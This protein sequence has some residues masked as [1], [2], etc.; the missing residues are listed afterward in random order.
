VIGTVETRKHLYTPLRYPGGKTSLSSYFGKVLHSNG[1][2][3]PTY[4]EP[5]AGGA[6][7]ALSLL[8]TERVSQIVV[9]DLDPAIAAFWRAVLGS[10]E[11]MIKRVGDVELS[12]NEWRRQKEL[13][14][15]ESA[16]DLDRGFATL[17]L[18]RTNR[19]GIL[20]SGPIGGYDQSGKWKIGARFNRVTLAE[21]L[22]LIAKYRSRIVLREEDGGSVISEFSPAGAFLYVDPPY[23]EQGGELYL[24]SFSDLDHED[25][26]D[27]LHKERLGRW[28][29][30]Y[31]NVPR[32]VEL[33]RDLKH[34]EFDLRYSAHRSRTA[35]E[36][37]VF[38]DG[39]EPA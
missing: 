5:F 38:S 39:I 37:M 4:V 8:L 15:S 24:N 14:L 28:I 17:F 2:V 36:L 10:S 9:N 32:A 19:S 13:H 3:E 23:F 12:V 7:A 22:A 35:K 29:L 34:A 1:M 26:A 21:R 20:R 27:L 33:Y 18:N 6:G 25:L 31:D 11:E 16:S 30:T